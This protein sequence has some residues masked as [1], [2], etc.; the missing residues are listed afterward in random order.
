M[1]KIT[2]KK[3]IKKNSIEKPEKS[4]KTISEEDIRKR[5][6]EIFLESGVPSSSEQDNWLNAE[7]ELMGFYK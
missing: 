7:R 1:G 3:N 5:A 6:Y 2:S 4:I